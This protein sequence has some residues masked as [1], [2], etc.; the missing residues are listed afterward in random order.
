[1]LRR[2]P[3]RTPPTRCSAVTAARSATSGPGVSAG[4]ATSSPSAGPAAGRLVAGWARDVERATADRGDRRRLRDLQRAGG[5][6]IDRYAPDRLRG[7]DPGITR[8]TLNQ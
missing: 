2:S 4:G 7:H 5:A 3:G 8:I 1:M 6:G